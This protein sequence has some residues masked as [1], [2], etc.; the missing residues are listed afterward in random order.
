MSFLNANGADSVYQSHSESNVAFSGFL[1]HPS[2]EVLFCLIA[3]SVIINLK[4]F[5]LSL[6]L[7]KVDEIFSCLIMSEPHWVI[8]KLQLLQLCE[9]AVE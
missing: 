9:L 5:N 2:F 4:P 8:S 7:D 3:Q 1:S 6:S